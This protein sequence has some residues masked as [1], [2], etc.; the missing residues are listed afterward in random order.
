[1]EYEMHFRHARADSGANATVAKTGDRGLLI[2]L[3]WAAG[4]EG[5]GT[6]DQKS[7]RLRAPDSVVGP[8]LLASEHR[9][10]ASEQR[11]SVTVL[12]GAFYRPCFLSA[13]CCYHFAFRF[14]V[15]RDLYS[16]GLHICANRFAD[17]AKFNLN[18]MEFGYGLL[19]GYWHVIFLSRASFRG[20]SHRPARW[21]IT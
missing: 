15:T 16:L 18:L 21:C 10:W 2:P 20:T 7:N 4:A 8:E 1:M 19:L 5:I 6:F 17:Y 12:F 13:G 14:A 9:D 3:R 11:R